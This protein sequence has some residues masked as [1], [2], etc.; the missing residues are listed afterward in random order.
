[1]C[2]RGCSYRRQLLFFSRWAPNTSR[3]PVSGRLFLQGSITVFFRNGPRTR[4]GIL[5]RASCSYNCCVF[6]IW[7]PNTS[8]YRV[9]GRL[10]LPVSFT[11]FLRN[12]PRRCPGILYRAGCSY[13]SCVF[14]TSRPTILSRGGCLYRRQVQCF[15]KIGPEHVPLS[16]VGQVVVTIVVFFEIWD[17]ETKENTSAKSVNYCFF[18]KW[19]PNTSR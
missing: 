19:A 7:A 2:R 15:F 14:E 6:E 17:S 9:S 3:Y 5:C 18:L 10:F 12:G 11:V 16:C 4:P 1:M 13:N 8:R